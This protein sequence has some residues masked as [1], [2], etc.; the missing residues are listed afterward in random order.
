MELKTYQ[1]NNAT[2]IEI[3]GHLDT[4]T[5]LEYEKQMNKIVEDGSIVLIVDC[6]KF[7]CT[8]IFG[9]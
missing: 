6:T 2:I 7:R 3:T 5:S 4:M 8:P 9:Q 1:E